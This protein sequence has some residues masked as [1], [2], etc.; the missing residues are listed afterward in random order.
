MYPIVLKNQTLKFQF[1]AVQHPSLT[2]CAVPETP[3]PARG[4][5]G[6]GAGEIEEEI[7]RSVEVEEDE[8]N[9]FEHRK[10]FDRQRVHLC[11][12]RRRD[13]DAE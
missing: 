12:G 8:S 2:Q 4:S 3:L 5:E 10:V 6:A 9:S 1:I 7:D 13:A 11:G